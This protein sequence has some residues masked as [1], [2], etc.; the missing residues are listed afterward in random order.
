MLISMIYDNFNRGSIQ[1]RE[2]KQQII[3]FSGIRYGKITPTDIDGAIE[4]HDK[5]WIFFEI[6]HRDTP[7]PRGQLLALMRIADDLQKSGKPTIICLCR[8]NVD[9][10]SMDVQAAEII[11]SNLYFDKNWHK[12]GNA[13]LREM[14]DRF[15]NYVD[16]R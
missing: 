3:D 16:R 14:C 5:A 10:C 13:T 7:I 2:R 15:I 4:Y 12:E 6:K 1:N 8:H 11:V 9:D